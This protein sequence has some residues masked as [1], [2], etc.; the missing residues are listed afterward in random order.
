MLEDERKCSF[1]QVKSRY[2]DAIFSKFVSRAEDRKEKE[3]PTTAEDIET[4]FEIFHAI[5]H[6]P[7]TVFKLFRFIDQLLLGETSRTI[8]QSMV[9]LFQSGVLHDRT[10]LNLAK[11]FYLVLAST[12]ELQYGNVLLATLTKSQLQTVIDNDWPFFTNHT[13]LVKMCLKNSDCGSTQDIIQEIG[14]IV[15]LLEGVHS[16]KKLYSTNGV[17]WGGG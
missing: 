15:F 17:G 1:E 13:D 10:S 3:E 12:L 7:I 2:Q 11:E 14:F 8:I 16:K 5:I 6:C 4:G 9:N